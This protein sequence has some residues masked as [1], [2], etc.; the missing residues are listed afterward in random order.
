MED[1]FL[2]NLLYIVL[3]ILFWVVPFVLRYLKRR[4]DRAAAPKEA[5]EEH[6]PEVEPAPVAIVPDPWASLENDVRAL[7]LPLEELTAQAE[8]L[9][10]RCS[11]PAL[12][13]FMQVLD[14]A[15]SRPAAAWQEAIERCLA[16]FGA[17]DPVRLLED[18]SA[19]II[20]MR[21]VLGFLDRSILEHASDGFAGRHARG[22]ALARVFFGRLE[23][24]LRKGG[25]TPANPMFLPVTSGAPD[26]FLIMALARTRAVPFDARE[27]RRAN[28]LSWASVARDVV[29]WS[30]Y[31][32]P[33]LEG[34]IEARYA[35]VLGAVGY[36]PAPPPQGLAREVYV[37]T[38]TSL[39]LG[40]LYTR[41]VSMGHAA[42]DAGVSNRAID[43]ARVEERDPTDELAVHLEVML[44]VLVKEQ[45]DGLGSS[46][47][48]DD[49]T[50][51]FDHA[52]T[53]RTKA[54]A[55]ALAADERPEAPH[56]HVVAGAMRAALDDPTSI[57]RLAG[58]VDQALG[59]VRREDVW[60]QEQAASPR[61][62]Q[63]DTGFVSPRAVREAIVIGA[64]MER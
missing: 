11:G 15:V 54:V 41:A 6:F 14:E 62:P 13:P 20:G 52:D 49:P 10:N 1:K 25:G 32:T 12:A 46:R 40:R 7:T 47:L 38:V 28:P 53:S 64:L 45:L 35:S 42:G 24:M 44:H 22:R 60:K 8:E 58:P 30:L 27:A 29:S 4:A 51:R 36:R 21:S 9:K 33:G 31:R 19:T 63:P 59:V 56:F 17:C 48:S 16:D 34:E 23:N 37:D 18:T 50:L 39:L 3:V 26:P 57:P 5:P 55:A 61:A 43:L 2:T